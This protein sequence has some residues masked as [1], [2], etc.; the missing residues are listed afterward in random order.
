MSNFVS[1]YQLQINSELF[2][3]KQRELNS[4]VGNL[5]LNDVKDD[6]QFIR[7]TKKIKDAILLR[8]VTFHDPKI[9]NNYQIEKTF[10]ASYQDMWGGKKLVNI[11]T[12]EFS[13]DGSPELF[14][15]SPNNLSYSSSSNMR[16]YQPYGNAIS[17]EVELFTLE[18]ER[19]LSEARKQM[20]MTFGVINGNNL[21]AQQWSNS[22]EQ[23]IDHL[24]A[25]KRKELLDLYS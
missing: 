21:Q 25:I 8:P 18:K 13:F 14:N 15:Y 17:V 2:S 7:S 9:T 16:V 3:D 24:L 5:S 20:E 19:A 23:N 6:E 22:I 11:I 10:Q 12:V 1:P 4:L